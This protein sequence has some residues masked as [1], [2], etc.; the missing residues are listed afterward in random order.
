MKKNKA[1]KDMKKGRPRGCI[2]RLLREGSTLRLR[3]N[4]DRKKVREWSG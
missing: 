1:D 4:T 2:Y 3:L